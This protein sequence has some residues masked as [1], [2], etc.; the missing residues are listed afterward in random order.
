MIWNW[1]R[2]H[3]RLVD[4][5]IVAVV[6][7]GTV[8]AAARQ[9]HPVRGSILAAAASLGLAWRRR[10]PAAV[11]TFATVATITAAAAGALVQ[12]FPLGVALYTLAAARG[13]SARA[14]GAV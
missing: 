4:A 3:P 9:D 13:R 7:L 11:V 2:R 5:G 12:P 1:L 10:H 6:L 14:F 8:V